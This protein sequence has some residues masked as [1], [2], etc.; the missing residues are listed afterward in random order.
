M[1]LYLLSIFLFYL[2]TEF[3]IPPIFW[4][5]DQ[6]KQINSK[7]K[8][9]L[10]TGIILSL[11]TP[12]FYYFERYHTT[13]IWVISTFIIIDLI[14]FLLKQKSY[15]HKF[16][17]AQITKILIFAFL[18]APLYYKSVEED[19]IYRIGIV[20][21]AYLINTI[22]TST[23]ISIFLEHKKINLGEFYTPT[24]WDKYLG[25]LERLLVLTF[26]F[27]NEFPPIGF[28]I[29]AKFLYVIFANSHRDKNEISCEIVGSLF[30]ILMAILVGLIFN[31]FLI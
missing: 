14:L 17:Y 21:L 19:Q 11:A 20:L 5:R 10:H 13:T 6:L 7:Q 22:P 3:F 27:L 18:L 1:Y 2:L 23:L 28:L 4:S 25:I 24:P 12:I 31:T 16:L 15:F 8:F 26:I 9:L 30:S 29:I